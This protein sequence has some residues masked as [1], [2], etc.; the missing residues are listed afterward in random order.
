M[1]VSDWFRRAAMQTN[2]PDYKSDSAEHEQHF[3]VVPGDIPIVAIRGKEIKHIGRSDDLGEQHV[4]RPWL[5]RLVAW[6]RRFA[7]N[8]RRTNRDCRR[9][10]ELSHVELR[11]ALTFLIRV[12]QTESF[13]EEVADWT[14]KKP[15]QPSSK[16]IA[17]NPRLVDGVMRVGGRLTNAPVPESRKHLITLH[18]Q[19]PFTKI[20]M[21]YYHWMLYHAGQQLLI[22][23]TIHRCVDCF[24]TKPRVHEQLMADLPSVRVCPAAAFQNFCGPFYIRYPIRRSIPVKCFVAIFVCLVTKAVHMEVVADLSTQAFLAAFKR[25]V[26]TRGKPQLVMCDNATIFYAEEDGIEFK[27]IPPRSP[28]FGGL[29]EVAVKSFKAHF[30]KTIGSR[31]LTYDELHTVVQ[32]IAAILNSRPLTP[33]S[34][35]PDD[36]DALTPGHFLTGRPLAAVPEPDLQEIPENRLALW[37]RTQAFVQQIWRKWKPEYLSNLQ[38]RTRWTKQRDNIKIGTMVL[39]KEDNLPPLKWKLARVVAVYKG[40]TLA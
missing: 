31:T 26:A 28:N 9:T 21:S 16:L 25:F 24:K 4:P 36:F 11:E 17:L 34:I 33:L 15:I 22:A 7:H 6:V 8:A 2:R 23:A 40:T 38:N 14:K 30:R 19:H 13:P 3:I 18:H 20:V 32:Q 27:F 5:I 12:A 37:Q 39:L 10:G 1:C 35:D 29:W